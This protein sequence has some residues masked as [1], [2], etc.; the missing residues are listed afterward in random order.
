MMSRA[1]AVLVGIGALLVLI[2]F[3]SAAY[4]VDETEQVIIT[5][6]GRPVGEPV[7][8]PGLHF[9]TPFIQ[10]VHS[11][12]KRVMEW[13]SVKREIPTKEKRY[14]QVDSTARWRIA[15]SLTYF[16]TVRTEANAQSRL[17]DFL[18]SAMREVIASLN[19]IESVRSTNRPFTVSKDELFQ[20]SDEEATYQIAVGR[21]KIGEQIQDICVPKLNEFGI[22]LLD[23]R[24]RR[25][26]YIESVRREVYKR[27]ISERQR[28]AEYYR[29]EG[30]GMRMEIEG[31]TQKDQ[32]IIES[33]AYRTAEEIRGEADAEATRIYAEVYGADPEFYAFLKTLESYE[34]TLDEGLDLILTT[35]SDFF[36]FL[37]SMGE[38]PSSGQ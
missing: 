37:K 36:R 15:D 21:H 2:L 31:R 12:E 28:M 25:I 18:E 10:E 7:L 16:K 22:E 26:N 32:K 14:I 8:T 5:Q 35:D 29:S 20:D 4:T 30:M 6:F 17:D 27:M 13:D 24:L 33:G 38:S 9:K 34:H 3:F 11:F 19:L 23:V 1:L